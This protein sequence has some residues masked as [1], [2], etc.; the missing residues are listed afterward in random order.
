MPHTCSMLARFFLCKGEIFLAINTL[1]LS[2]MCEVL[3]KTFPLARCWM[4][5]MSTMA[6]KLDTRNFLSSFHFTFIGRE[7]VDG[8]A[9]SIIFFIIIVDFPPFVPPESHCHS[10]LDS[11]CTF[12]W[13]RDDDAG[14][15]FNCEL[16]T[17]CSHL[18]S[19]S[20]TLSWCNY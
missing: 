19:S 12:K 10:I 8:F 15:L 7:R 16:C 11:S 18:Q 2:V 3:M 13:E 1:N 14:K 5:K 4:L 6:T 20:S 17:L 9:N